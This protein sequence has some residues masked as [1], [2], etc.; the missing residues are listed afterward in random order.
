MD[1]DD[2]INTRFYESLYNAA[3]NT[4]ADVAVGSFINERSL[5][6]SVGYV[7]Q[8]VVS[9]PQ[10]KIDITQVNLRGFVWRYLISRKFWKNQKLQY[11]PEMRYCEDMGVMTRMVYACNM[12]VTVP[13][14]VYIYKYRMN[15]LLT[16][17]DSNN[18]LRNRCYK[19]AVAD[20]A[21]FLQDK[22]LI[23]A[24]P[25][26][27]VG[28]LYLF[29][30]IPVMNFLYSQNNHRQKYYLFGKIPLFKIRWKIS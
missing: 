28:R 14:A 20:V 12:I 30:F 4:G 13:D 7:H 15:S 27:R 9:Q 1:A 6:E 22:H 11:P 25:V 23:S 21:Q 8:L 19:Q 3:K 16:S 17:N 26:V 10:D 24:K 29:G 2:I 18:E 5:P